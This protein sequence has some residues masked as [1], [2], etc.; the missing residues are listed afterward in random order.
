[1][2]ALSEPT[3]ER[4]ARQA[5]VAQ[6]KPNMFVADID[7]AHRLVIAET[8]VSTCLLPIVDPPVRAK[9]TI[10]F[11]KYQIIVW[12]KGIIAPYAKLVNWSEYE[13]ITEAL[14]ELT[15]ETYD[16]LRCKQVRERI[17]PRQVAFVPGLGAHLLALEA[18]IGF[19]VDGE[20]L[21]QAYHR[22]IPV[23]PILSQEAYEYDGGPV[24]FWFGFNFHDTILEPM[25]VEVNRL[26][27]FVG[28][29][30][31][32]PIPFSLEVKSQVDIMI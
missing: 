25:G 20:F 14:A 4:A 6:S 12:S 26:A 13:N 18:C 21:C 31:R 15:S 1:M 30:T 8:L 22:G 11:P 5:L 19:H 17:G 28:Q 23:E 29:Y 3:I 7:N 10:S 2:R 32:E 24:G 16:V 27:S 9:V